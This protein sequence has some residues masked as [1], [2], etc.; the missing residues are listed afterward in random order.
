M[1]PPSAPWATLSLQGLVR[2]QKLGVDPALPAGALDLDPVPLPTCGCELRAY[3]GRPK[4][5][6]VS[7]GCRPYVYTGTLQKDEIP[8]LRRGGSLGRH[9]IWSHLGRSLG[10]GQRRNSGRGNH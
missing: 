1:V 5:G 3:G 7:G 9:G 8:V 2:R 6:R 4:N 10:G